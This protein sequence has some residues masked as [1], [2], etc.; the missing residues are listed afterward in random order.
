M[1]KKHYKII[2][3]VLNGYYQ[4][5]LLFQK[6]FINGDVE[7]TSRVLFDVMVNELMT[8]LKEDNSRFNKEKFMTALFKN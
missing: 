7:T 8:V 3:K 2:A 6:D 1:T 5:N 4:N